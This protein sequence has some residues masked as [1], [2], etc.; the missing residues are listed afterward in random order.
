MEDIEKYLL[1]FLEWLEVNKKLLPLITIP[2]FRFVDK[3]QIVKDFIK[4]DKRDFMQSMSV[5]EF[6]E[7]VEEEAKKDKLREEVLKAFG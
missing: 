3:G 6:S 7:K 2:N 5:D 4:Q 1:D